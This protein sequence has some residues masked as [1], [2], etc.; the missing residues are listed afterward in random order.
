MKKNYSSQIGQFSFAKKAYYI[1]F[2]M[3]SIFLVSLL[4]MAIFGI[5]TD[6]KVHKKAINTYWTKED[7]AIISLQ[8]RTTTLPVFAID[9]FQTDRNFQYV[10]NRGTIMKL[11]KDRNEKNPSLIFNLSLTSAHK[12]LHLN[13]PI[14]ITGKN[15]DELYLLDKSNDIYQYNGNKKRWTI[16]KSREIVPDPMFQKIQFYK[17]DLYVLDTATNQIRVLSQGQLQINETKMIHYAEFKEQ[18]KTKIP[19]FL[20]KGELDISRAIDF[21]INKDFFFVL[22]SN[23][24]ILKINRKDENEFSIYNINEAN[25]YCIEIQCSADKTI[26]VSVKYNHDTD[27][28]LVAD[29]G[30][31][32]LVII[33]SQTGN[34]TRQYI[35]PS[36][37]EFEWI[38][39]IEILANVVSILAGNNIFQFS[40]DQNSKKFSNKR[41]TKFLTKE[42]TDIP[43]ELRVIFPNNPYLIQLLSKNKD[44]NF[45]IEGALLPDRNVLYPGT[46]RIYRSGIHRGLDISEKDSGTT[47]KKGTPVKSITEG[48]VIRADHNYKEMSLKELQKLIEIT[49]EKGFTP[50]NI[51]N[52]LGGRQ[53]WISHE[54][55]VISK[56]KHLSAI[57]PHIRVKTHVESSQTIGRVGNSGTPDGITGVNNFVHL[58]FEIWYGKEQKWYLGQWATIAETR[59]LYQELFKLEVRPAYLDIR[60]DW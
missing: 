35:A 55:G 33:D 32:R 3:I 49:K 16:L 7:F 10:I 20:K 30:L 41:A 24:E 57:S 36:I 45:P 14:S 27:E 59:R 31:H 39:D 4:F 13:E 15:L 23:G 53:V 40:L 43:K 12:L 60:G 21:S 37:L 48:V 1:S 11:D 8:D 19:R 46:R 26:A 6:S 5:D 56:F 9:L 50:E 34:I 29:K 47:I 38:S 52:K 54:G 18:L 17:E 58:H 2:L 51:L 22:K 28:L 44:F 25:R 42:N